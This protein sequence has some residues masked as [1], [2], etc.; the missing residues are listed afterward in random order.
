MYRGDLVFLR[1]VEFRDASLI[2]E[3]EKNK[4]IINSTKRDEP[5]TI[6]FIES[7]IMEQ[8]NVLIS[9][10]VRYVIC[11]C[12]SNI[13]VGVVD[14]Y[15]IDFNI[16]Y[17]DVGIAIVDEINRKKGFASEALNLIR[18]FAY[19]DLGLNQLNAMVALDN[20]A[21]NKLFKSAGY[22]INTSF[23]TEK[24]MNMFTI[25]L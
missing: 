13:A 12:N 17:A 8:R 3:W 9:G 15:N 19:N 11:N 16:G 2:Y 24:K 5:L 7:I 4:E 23:I 14:L 25:E 18:E 21:S 1:L 10:Q 22:S 20:V 6:A